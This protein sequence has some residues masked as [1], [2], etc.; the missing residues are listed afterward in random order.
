[1]LCLLFYKGSDFEL[2]ALTDSFQERNTDAKAE[3]KYSCCHPQSPK[4]SY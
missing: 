3:I 1:L 4:Y 2:Q